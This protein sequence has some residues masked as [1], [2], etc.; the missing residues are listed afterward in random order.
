MSSLFCP[1]RKNGVSITEVANKASE[2]LG[3]FPV[4]EGEPV[5]VDQRQ[6]QKKER[7]VRAPQKPK[8]VVTVKTVKPVEVAATSAK[9]IAVRDMDPAQVVRLEKTN[10]LLIREV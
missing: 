3:I 10:Q 6:K 2:E 1:Q 4:E 8:A 9:P 5:A 7:R